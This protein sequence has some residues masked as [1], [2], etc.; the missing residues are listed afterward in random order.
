MSEIGKEHAAFTE[1]AHPTDRHMVGHLRFALGHVQAEEHA[2]GVGI[3]V[4]VL[5]DLVLP[6]ELLT[7][8]SHGGVG[9]FVVEEAVG[10]A[11]V[12]GVTGEGAVDHLHIAIVLL[13]GV[14][15]AVC[16][17]EAFAGLDELHQRIPRIAGGQQHA[18]GVKKDAVKLLQIFASD[19]LNGV[20]RI[21]RGE[22]AALLADLRQHA[23]H[24]AS[25]LAGAVH[26]L[27]AKPSGLGDHQNLFRRGLHL[28][29]GVQEH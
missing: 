2:H 16:T 15:R 10:S 11:C 1:A 25:V 9:G 13:E 12:P 21:H 17:H 20:L 14:G 18:G 4:V 26:G 7:E 22:H 6:H 19:A 3:E 29:R 8:H 24:L 27:M 5:V 23:F 28:S